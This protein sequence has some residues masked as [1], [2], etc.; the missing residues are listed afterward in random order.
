M[1][2]SCSAQGRL[3]KRSEQ[4]PVEIRSEAYGPDGHRVVS[5]WVPALTLGYVSH[6]HPGAEGTWVVTLLVKAL[7]ASTF[8]SG[9]GHDY[10]IC[11]DRVYLL[12]VT[13]SSA[14]W[15]SLKALKSCTY[16]GALKID[17][18]AEFIEA[19]G[20]APD[21]LE[22]AR[23]PEDICIRPRSGGGCD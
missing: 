12:R 4:Q 16:P 11:A 23:L 19:L 21:C 9:Y 20:F 15:S 14:D 3:F 13:R 10:K 18:E 22:S 8:Q 2:A 6:E 1:N 17:R 7:G 5:G